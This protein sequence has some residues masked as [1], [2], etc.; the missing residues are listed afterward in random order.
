VIEMIVLILKFWNEQKSSTTPF[1]G[2]QYE[3]FPFRESNADN[4][5][6]HINHGSDDCVKNRHKCKAVD[7]QLTDEKGNP[8]GNLTNPVKIMASIPVRGKNPKIF[9]IFGA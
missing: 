7:R 2:F 3:N 9:V 6:N 1:N 4:Q 5:T 8:F